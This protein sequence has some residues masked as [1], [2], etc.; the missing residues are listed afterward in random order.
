MTNAF[1]CSSVGGEYAAMSMATTREL[2]VEFY[3][4]YGIRYNA[5]LSIWGST[6]TKNGPS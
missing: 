4:R 3:A 5:P 2:N 1:I 6:R